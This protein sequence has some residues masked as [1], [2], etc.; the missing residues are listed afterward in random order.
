MAKQKE[1]SELEVARAEARRLKSENKYLRKELNRMEKRNRQYEHNLTD[2][3]DEEFI[4]DEVEEDDREDCPK[5]DEK[6]DPVDIGIRIFY[7]C[8][9]GYRKTIKKK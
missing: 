5:C 2:P 4:K 1:R 3:D 7:S 9:C 6:L 8:S